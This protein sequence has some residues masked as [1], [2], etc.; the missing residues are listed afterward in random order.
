MAGANA[1]N[2]LVSV[3]GG[4]LIPQRGGNGVRLAVALG[5]DA[6]DLVRACGS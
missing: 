5:V 2:G 1:S 6:A 3:L 4:V